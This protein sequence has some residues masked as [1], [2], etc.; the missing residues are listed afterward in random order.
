MSVNDA[1]FFDITIVN[2]LETVEPKAPVTVLVELADSFAAEESAAVVHYT[3]DE[4][5][6]VETVDP[7][8]ASAGTLIAR[9]GV[10]PGRLLMVKKTV[11]II[12]VD[13]FRNRILRGFLNQLGQT[14]RK[15][16]Q[17]CTPPY[18]LSLSH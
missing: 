9:S 18:F 3:E 4:V 17:L 5:K 1:R 2:G 15:C 10:L 6:V 7:E 14:F 12:L 16:T 13:L 8:E 11:L